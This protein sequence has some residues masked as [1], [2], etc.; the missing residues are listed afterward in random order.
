MEN[1]KNNVL[2]AVIKENG[3][4]ILD[5]EESKFKITDKQKKNRNN[6]I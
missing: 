6:F 2:I 4:F 3:N 5:Y 1:Q